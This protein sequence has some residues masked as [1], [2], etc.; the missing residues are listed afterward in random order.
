MPI[1]KVNGG[2]KYGEK[3]KLYKGP[4]AK[5]KAIKQA[6]AIQYSQ[7]KAGKSPHKI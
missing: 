5:K 2:Y 3:G 1:K 7:K 6:V 4:G